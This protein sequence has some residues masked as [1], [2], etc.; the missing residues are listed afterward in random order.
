MFSSV[1]WAAGLL[2]KGVSMPREAGTTSSCRKA[3]K[4]SSQQ[5]VGR[6]MWPNMVQPNSSRKGKCAGN[7]SDSPLYVWNCRQKLWGNH[8]YEIETIICACLNKATN[9][10]LM[11]SKNR[12]GFNKLRPKK[13]ISAYKPYSIQL[14]G[15]C[16][17]S[18]R[19][20]I[21]SRWSGN[22]PKPN[23]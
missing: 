16:K 10:R 17:M 2:T 7:K 3:W 21:Y 6:Y 19:L 13:T 22:Q 14:Q 23:E 20:K 4:K 18:I 11:N 8:D 9:S 12:Q 15:S 5:E 1:V